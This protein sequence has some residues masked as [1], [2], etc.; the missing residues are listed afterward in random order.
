MPG[1]T[2]FLRE[3]QA[4]ESAFTVLFIW[5]GDG[6]NPIHYYGIGIDQINPRFMGS[7]NAFESSIENERCT[8]VRFVLKSQS[9]ACIAVFSILE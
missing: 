2:E 8:I 5:E 6:I 4:R 3:T 7:R 1:V 9:T